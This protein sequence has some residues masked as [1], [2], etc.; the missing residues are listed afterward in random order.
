MFIKLEEKKKGL[1]LLLAIIL[2]ITTLIKIITFNIVY[3]YNKNQLFDYDTPRYEE[4]ALHWLKTG[5]LALEPEA[6]HSRALNA[7]PFYSVVIGTVYR[8]FGEK[9]RYAVIVVQI[10]LSTLTAFFVYLIAAKLWSRSTGVIVAL[11]MAFEPLQFTYSQVMLSEA[12]STSLTTLFIV[13][14]TYMMLGNKKYVYVFALLIGVVLATATMTRPINYYLILPVVVGIILFR[15]SINL[16]GI[17]LLRLVGCIVL[18]YVLIVGSWHVRNG[19]VTGAYQFTDNGSTL[20]LRYLAAP[21]VAAKKGIS[22]ETAYKE[23]KKNLPTY[24]TFAEK[25]AVEKQMAYEI[26]SDNKLAYIM[27]MLKNVPSVLIGPGFDRFA[28]HFGGQEKGR[29]QPIQGNVATTL[30]D[31]IG[32]WTGYQAWYVVLMSCVVGFT[33]LMYLLAFFGIMTIRGGKEKFFIIHV[34]MLGFV[35]FFLVFST[36][37]SFAY[38]RLRMPMTPIFV[39]YAGYALHL[40]LLRF[41]VLERMG[42]YLTPESAANECQPQSEG[43]M[44]S[45]EI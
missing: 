17:N 10:I 32:A 19:L 11:L 5:S 24:T 33:L 15:Q 36:G 26:M 31:K 6:I 21:L 18:P 12:L 38:S 40:V 28:D 27:L 30:A 29:Y 3:Q 37:N 13:F 1:Y 34:L 16:Q 9:N 20:V 43:V 39:L 44:V 41:N 14:F 7:A 4:P 22:S 42:I 35:L 25:L 2:L 23:I 8:L 45:K